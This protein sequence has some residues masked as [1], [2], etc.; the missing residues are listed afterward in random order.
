MHKALTPQL[1]LNL[2]ILREYHL[3]HVLGAE[4][5][6]LSFLQSYID[7]LTLLPVDRVVITNELSSLL[8]SS[9]LEEGACGFHLESVD[10]ETYLSTQDEVHLG[11][12]LIFFDKYFVNGICVI[13]AARKEAHGNVEEKFLL[14]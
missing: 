12:F 7:E 8:S 9:Y 3:F 6:T 10:S 13:K 14:L 11:H 1:C 5:E 4:S 2:N